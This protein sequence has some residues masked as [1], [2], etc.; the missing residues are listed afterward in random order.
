MAGKK[1]L[2][3]IAPK[4]FRD[5]EYLVPKGILESAG[6]S[7]VTASLDRKLC[8]GMFGAEVMPALKINEVKPFFYDGIVIAGGQ[9]TPSL[10]ESEEVLG[11]VR[12]FFSEKKLTS[13]ICLAPVVLA[14]AGVLSGRKATVWSSALDKRGIDTLKASGATY[15]PTDVVRDGII[16]TG[17]GPESAKKFAE[18]ILDV[19]G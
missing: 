19:L 7:I 3:L 16:V 15:L 18:R 1:L 4:D 13:A 8:R 2:Y 12:A 10:W 9:G 11:L 14:K 17:N 5:E 6:N